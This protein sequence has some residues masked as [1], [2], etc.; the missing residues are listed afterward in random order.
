MSDYV[1]NPNTF[2]VVTP[3]GAYHAAM[4][5]PD[6]AAR[7]LLVRLLGMSHSIALDES[8]LRQIDPEQEPRSLLELLYRMQELG[9]IHGADQLMNVPELNMERDVPMLLGALSSEGR[10][11]LADGQ[12]FH[13]ANAGFAHEVEEELSALAAEVATLQQRHRFLLENNLRSHAKGWAAVDAAGNG[14]IGFW[15]MQVA[16]QVFVLVVAGAPKFDQRTFVDLVWWLFRR[17]APSL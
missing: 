15:P 9:W 3:A 4:A 1:L 12:G 16:D 11:L 7:K 5:A 10:A 14:Q 8:G 13:L 2:A 17:Y 6:D